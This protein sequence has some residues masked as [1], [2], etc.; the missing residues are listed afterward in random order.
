MADRTTEEA[1]LGLQ[2]ERILGSRLQKHF[3]WRALD[4]WTR[5][6]SVKCSRPPH[7]SRT[8]FSNALSGWQDLSM[9]LLME[10]WNAHIQTTE[11]TD[12]AIIALVWATWPEKL[13]E[14]DLKS[15]EMSRLYRHAVQSA[16]YYP[17]DSLIGRS[18]YHRE[19]FLLWQV[20]FLL[21]YK[22][23]DNDYITTLQRHRHD[24]AIVASCQRITWNALPRFRNETAEI[25]EER[26]ENFEK[27]C[28]FTRKYLAHE[29]SRVTV[30]CPWLRLRQQQ[31]TNADSKEGL[32]RF[33][34]DV[35]VGKTVSTQDMEG[36][37]RYLVISHTWGR[38]KMPEPWVTV[39]GVEWQIPQNSLF[40]VREL[41]NILRRMDVT[42]KYIWMDLVCIPQ[43]RSIPEYA[44]IYHAEIS[45][46]GT[47][48]GTA[49]AGV[50]WLSDYED[51]N[52][53]RCAIY[54]LC[55]KYL[56]KTGPPE[57][58]ALAAKLLPVFSKFAE[59]PT[60]L[61]MSYEWNG[62]ASNP[63]QPM[64]WFSSLWTLQEACI[65]PQM[66]FLNRSGQ[67]FRIGNDLASLDSLVALLEEVGVSLLK[68]DRRTSVATRLEAVVPSLARGPWELFV[69]SDQFELP[70]VLK[71]NPIALLGMSNQRDCRR[72]R[73]QAIMSAAGATRWFYGHV[74]QFSKPPDETALVLGRFPMAFLT[75][76][77][78]QLGASFFSAVSLSDDLMDIALPTPGRERLGF[79]VIGSMLPFASKPGRAKGTH[80]W[81]EEHQDHPS[82]STWTLE[83]DGSVGIQAVG[84]VASS[85]AQSPLDAATDKK[86]DATIMGPDSDSPCC[87]IAPQV[88]DLQQWLRTFR[89]G[90]YLF[91]VSL[92]YGGPS[93]L[94]WGIILQRVAPPYRR[95]V[96]DDPEIAGLQVLVK[97]GIYI[98]SQPIE[99]PD[100]QKVNWLVL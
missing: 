23:V 72:S 78:G 44:E 51:W 26:P 100:S 76:L 95:Q 56:E 66:V 43:D 47:I 65:M 74:E 52:G 31:V 48:F 25:P 92:C 35:K 18:K 80:V 53:L 10:W 21:C 82:V 19:L 55:L 97:I 24:A 12:A 96:L 29:I 17:Y 69:L 73:A 2:V 4:N 41:P 16:P 59:A 11:L 62:T 45:R 9:S 49:A 32:P 83:P 60:G 64:G 58:Q 79:A 33:L 30:P 22:E 6:V 75:E 71:M 77:R 5:T 54:W 89:P 8:E 38:W 99:M 90:I 50:I 39:A 86:L 87:T 13:V 27:R 42:A 68:S 36:R 3:H 94:D 63:T 1:P 14:S 28:E 34:W 88:V 40:D 85:I 46:Q 84:I 70:S 91:A 61:W 37:P 20:E 93:G 15:P 7:P 57:H 81:H 67:P 98:L